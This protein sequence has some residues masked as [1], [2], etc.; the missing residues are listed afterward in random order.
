[1]VRALL[2][3]HALVSGVAAPGRAAGATVWPAASVSF[4]STGK[5]GD[6]VAFSGCVSVAI[7]SSTVVKPLPRGLLASGGFATGHADGCLLT[8]SALDFTCH[9]V[10]SSDFIALELFSDCQLSLSAPATAGM[11]AKTPG[12]PS[13]LVG[14]TVDPWRAGVS[15]PS[16]NVGLSVAASLAHAGVQPVTGTLSGF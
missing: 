14:F 1:M 3:V 13:M 2:L 15:S 4:I 5:T 10:K 6:I 7:T 12:D 9:E 16:E 8:E 11:G